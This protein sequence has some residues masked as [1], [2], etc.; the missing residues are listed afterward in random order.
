M[1]LYLAY[2]SNLNVNQMLRRCPDAVMIGASAIENYK[3]VFRRGVLTIEP[4]KGLRVPVGVWSISESD[5]E[6][7]DIYEGFP[8]WYAKRLFQMSVNGKPVRAMAYV[9]TP[10]YPVFPP[11][12]RYYDVCAEGY[13]DF[14]FD[15][16]PLQAAAQ[17][18][19]AFTVTE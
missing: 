7:L 4:S 8:R 6:A 14:G 11:S 15:P 10:G 1:K 16:A 19:R 18:A 2:G 5:E 12:E 13:A 3:L 17:E 9:M